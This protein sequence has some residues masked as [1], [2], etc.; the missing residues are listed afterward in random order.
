MKVSL[1]EGRFHKP[2]GVWG[3]GSV[4]DAPEIIMAIFVE[5]RNSLDSLL[6]RL[7]FRQHQ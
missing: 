5:V 4:P 6:Q 7:I 3:G 1:V 2:G